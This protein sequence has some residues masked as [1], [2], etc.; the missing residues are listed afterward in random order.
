M[1]AKAVEMLLRQAIRSRRNRT[2][3]DIDALGRK[4]TA[5]D[6]IIGFTI[7]SLRMPGGDPAG[8]AGISLHAQNN[9]SPE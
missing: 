1:I 9:R 5:P 7:S 2:S 4:S 8:M 3:I 6:N